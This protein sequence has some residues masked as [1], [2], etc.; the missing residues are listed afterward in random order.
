MGFA[1]QEIWRCT[2]ICIRIDYRKNETEIWVQNL[3]QLPLPDDYML[4]EL[5]TLNR[6]HMKE[7]L[8]GKMWFDYFI[9]KTLQI[10]TKHNKTQNSLDRFDKRAVNNRNSFEN[11]LKTFYLSIYF[12]E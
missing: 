12:L 9:I 1:F 6:I 10:E 11:K 4:Q 3:A 2:V 5:R 7:L 8:S